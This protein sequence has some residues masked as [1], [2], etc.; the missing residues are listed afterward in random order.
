MKKLFLPL[1]C[2]IILALVSSTGARMTLMVV[3]GGGAAVADLDHAGCR[4][5]GASTCTWCAWAVWSVLMLAGA[6]RAVA[7]VRARPEKTSH[8]QAALLSPLAR[9]A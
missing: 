9:G 1:I 3:G 7:K 6:H 4:A 2:F 5:Y 8:S